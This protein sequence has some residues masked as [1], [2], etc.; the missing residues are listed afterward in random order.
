MIQT[1]PPVLFSVIEELV[2]ATT[3]VGAPT[4]SGEGS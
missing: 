3:L 4:T 2:A 1:R